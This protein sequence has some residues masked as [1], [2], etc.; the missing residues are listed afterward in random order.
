MKEGSGTYNLS[1]YQNKTIQELLDEYESL[2]ILNKVDTYTILDHETP[3]TYLIQL[4]MEGKGEG[5]NTCI[6]SGTKQECSSD[7]VCAPGYSF[8]PNNDNLEDMA[9]TM[10]HQLTSMETE[11]YDWS[12]ANNIIRLSLVEYLLQYSSKG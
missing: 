10:F 6:T 5:H 3:K 9:S 4:V 12:G 7:F 11:N 1:L 2:D 8:L